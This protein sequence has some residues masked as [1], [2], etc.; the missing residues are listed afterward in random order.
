MARPVNLES[1]FV[2]VMKKE[3]F[4]EEFYGRIC[5]NSDNELGLSAKHTWFPVKCLDDD[6]EYRDNK[7]IKIY[8]RC[9]NRYSIKTS[10]EDRRLLW[11]RKE[12]VKEYTV[13]ELEKIVGHKIKVV[14]GN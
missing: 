6:F 3:G 9:S 4:D 1:D 12:E 7:I 13:E 2:V 14:G 10:N 5:F 8:G 11:E